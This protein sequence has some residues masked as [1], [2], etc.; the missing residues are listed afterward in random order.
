MGFQKNEYFL[1]Y[2]E[3]VDITKLDYLVCVC[4][5]GGGGGGVGGIYIHFKAFLKVKVQNGNIFGV[6]I[7]F[8]IFVGMLKFL[9]FFGVN[10]RC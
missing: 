2:K 6:A 10:S 3:I 8:H 9:I 5:G 7:I 1:G 4:G